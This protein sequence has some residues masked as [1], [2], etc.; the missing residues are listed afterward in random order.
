MSG[1]SAADAATTALAARPTAYPSASLSP[2]LWSSSTVTLNETPAPFRLWNI[3]SGDGSSLASLFFVYSMYSDASSVRVL[4]SAV[5]VQWNCYTPYPLALLVRSPPGLGRH[6]KVRP[7][8]V[9]S[10]PR[11]RLLF[12]FSASSGLAPS[13]KC[14]SLVPPKLREGINNVG[15]PAS[16]AESA[17]SASPLANSSRLLS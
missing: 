6:H 17:A 11:D 3:F 16:C 2:F 5:T 1:E 4:V 13:L 14:D 15:R 7:A 12:N 9:C 8:Q 10:G